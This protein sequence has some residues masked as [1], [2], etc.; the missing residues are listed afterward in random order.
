MHGIFRI[1]IFFSILVNCVLNLLKF[2]YMSHS[3]S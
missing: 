1:L 3:E 2:L